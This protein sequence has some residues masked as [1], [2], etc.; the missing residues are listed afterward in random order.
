[1]TDASRVLEGLGLNDDR[2]LSD[3]LVREIG[4]ATVP[5]SSFYPDSGE[6]GR[7]EVRFVFCKKMETLRQAVPLLQRLRERV[8]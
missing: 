3:Y 7:R 8:A 2:Q 5:G 1:M 4:L 6:H